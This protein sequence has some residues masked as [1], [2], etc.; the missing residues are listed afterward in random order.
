MCKTCIESHYPAKISI[1]LWNWL[2]TKYVIVFL[3]R[4][5]AKQLVVKLLQR[6]FIWDTSYLCQRR[7]SWD[8]RHWFAFFVCLNN[9]LRPRQMASIFQ[10]A[11]LNAFS[12]MKMH[13][14]WLKFHWSLFLRVQNNIIPA[15]VQ[16]MACR[17]VGAKPLS[18]PML[19]I[20]VTH[21]CVTRPQW[22][23]QPYQVMERCLNWFWVVVAKMFQTWLE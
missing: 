10:T 5:L 17:L 23:M 18:E 16:I 11:F 9:T 14:F 15:L 1:S 6:L 22:D 3:H 12:W 7:R 21:I 4:S 13:G 2:Y 8:H 20:F 19:V